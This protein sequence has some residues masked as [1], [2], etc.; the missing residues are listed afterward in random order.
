[1]SPFLPLSNTRS[2]TPCWLRVAAAIIASFSFP[3][4]DAPQ[5]ATGFRLATA[6]ACLSVAAS[7]AYFVGCLLENRQ[8]DRLQREQ[9]DTVEQSREEEEKLGDLSLDYRYML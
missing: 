4:E 8:R 5:Y 7:T 9:T 3:T 2:L 1:M 6:F